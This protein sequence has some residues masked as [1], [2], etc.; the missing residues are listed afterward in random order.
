MAFISP[1]SLFA[2]F[3]FPH[4]TASPSLTP[5]H[6]FLFLNLENLSFCTF[7]LFSL[8]HLFHSFAYFSS[9]LILHLLPIY[10]L[11]V[12]LPP[13][14]SFS[15]PFTLSFSLSPHSPSFTCS[16]LLHLTHLPFSHTL[17]SLPPSLHLPRTIDAREQPSYARHTHCTNPFPFHSLPV[18]CSN[19]QNPL[20]S[21]SFVTSARGPS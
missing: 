17:L 19:A 7:Y 16:L 5:R 15:C 21:S 9:P 11:L 18:H 10:F 13:S 6:S 20:R 14:T 12:H 1:Q 3:F 8:S 4:S 2:F